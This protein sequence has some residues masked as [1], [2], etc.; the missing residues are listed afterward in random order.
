MTLRADALALIQTARLDKPIGIW[1]LLWPTLAAL[2]LASG[3]VTPSFR[4]I[5]IF[6][7]G[8]LLTRSAGCIINDVIDRDLDSQVERT[9]T[10]P[11]AEGRLAVPSALIACATLFAL[12]F[13][14]VLATNT[15]TIWLALGALAIA[16][17][18]PFVKRISHYPQVVLAIAFS[19]GIPMAYTATTPITPPPEAW[20][21]FAANGLWTVAYD[22]QYAMTD[23]DFDLT[24]GIKSTAIAFGDLDIPI[25]KTLHLAVLAILVTLGMHTGIG[26]VYYFALALIG[27]LFFYQWQ[28]IK[29]R[30]PKLCFAAFRHNNWV[31]LT[32]FVGVFADTLV[33]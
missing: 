15:I 20:L 6:G 23:R 3:G 33:P 26:L 8:V 32:L 9:K 28:L 18:Y 21:L 10:R 16:C 7:L 5:L 13:V 29:N 22:T 4:L 1:L 17:S 27:A 24:A 11:L 31:G 30:D 25:I 19:W 2:W 12:A 14:L